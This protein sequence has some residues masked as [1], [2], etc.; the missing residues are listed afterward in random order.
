M[1]KQ[2]RLSSLC[3]YNYVSKP[4]TQCWFIEKIFRS[5]FVPKELITKFPTVSYVEAFRDGAVRYEMFRGLMVKIFKN[6]T[7]I[8]RC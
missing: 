1:D 2:L 5:T 8:S 3:S 6:L 7:C 4:Q